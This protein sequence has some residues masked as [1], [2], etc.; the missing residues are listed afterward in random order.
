MQK[1]KEEIIKKFNEKIQDLKIV[2]NNTIDSFSDFKLEFNTIKNKFLEL[3]EFIR[4]VRFRK[5]KGGDMK[6]RKIKI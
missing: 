6:K 5:N 2:S 4:D 3:V 1:I